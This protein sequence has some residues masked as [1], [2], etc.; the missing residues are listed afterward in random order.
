M[1]RKIM[2]LLAVLVAAYGVL[3]AVAELPPYGMSDNPVHNQ[4]SERYINDALEDTGALNMVTS[5]V[6]D[7]RAYD[8]MFETIVLFTAALA[9]V[10]TLKSD[11]R[12]ERSGK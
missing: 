11:K 3:I 4:V 12:K 5:I 8:T 9:V 7:Y 1:I 2:I 10:I 6:L